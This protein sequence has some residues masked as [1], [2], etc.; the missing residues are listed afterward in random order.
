[1]LIDLTAS[2][3]KG[4]EPTTEWC[5]ANLPYFVKSYE[6]PITKTSIGAGYAH[7]PL[8]RT[9]TNT[10]LK[11]LITNGSFESTT[12]WNGLV[13]DTS[14][15]LYGSYSSKMDTTTGTVIN[16]RSMIKPI[17]GHKYYGR[18]SIKTDG[19]PAPADCRFEWFAGDGAG[20][21]FVFGLNNGNHPT[22]YTESNIINVT[23]VNGTSYI[24]RN[25]AVAPKANI[26]SDGLMIVDLTEAFGAGKEPTK[27]WMDANVPFFEGSYSVPVTNFSIGADRIECTA[28][29][30]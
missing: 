30:E 29:Y 27:E 23:A 12:G 26:W 24:C 2:F 15:K 16:T 1:M 6:I 7:T 20:L 19:D 9:A 21:N 4:K 13:R 28:F 17:V 18:H 8:L 3:G 5:D 10:V 11:N 14:D 22:W 25:F